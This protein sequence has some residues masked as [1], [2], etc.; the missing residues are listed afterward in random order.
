MGKHAYTRLRNIFHDIPSTQMLQLILQKTP[1]TAGLNHFI[2]KHLQNIAPNMSVK[3]KVCI[4]MWDEVAIQPKVTYDTHKDII[5]GLEDWGNNR[6]VKI[7]DHV[8]VF[9]LRGLKSGWK[10]PISY[11]FC[12]KQTSTA[13][14]VRC[15][16]EHIHNINVLGFHIVATVC[17]HRSSN[18]SAIKELLSHTERKRNSQQRAQSK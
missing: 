9:M 10:V 15:I 7:A 3:D 8:L 11:N 2:L 5:C 14:L 6:T 13:Q 17:D 12:N 1:I 4:L 16:K 18:V